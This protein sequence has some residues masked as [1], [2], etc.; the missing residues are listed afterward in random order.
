MKVLQIVPTFR[1]AGAEIMCENLCYALRES[2]CDVVAV[3]LFTEHTPITDRL[4][5]SGI[6]VI[7]LDKKLGFDVSML[8][9]LKKTIR[10]EKPD[11]VHTHI[12]AA[13][14]AM[15]AA[16][17]CHVRTKVHTVHSIAQQEQSPVGKAVNKFLYK[18]CGVT[19]VAL[20]KEI[21]DSIKT[22]Y[23]LPEQKIPVVL[24]GIDLTRCQ[25]KSGYSRAEVFKIIQIGRF[26]D[27]KNHELVLRSFAVFVKKHPDAR[28]QLVGDGELR[29]AMMH[30][31]KE[32][33]IE[34][35]VEFVGLQ[36][37]VFPWLHSADLFLLPSKYE[38][39]PMSIVEAM[40]T[41]LPII[42][43]SVGGIPDMLE[44]GNDAILIG[45][46]QSEILEALERFYSSEQLRKTC[47]QNAKIKSINF[48][49]STMAKSYLA[50]YSSEAERTKPH[51]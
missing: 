24:N 31:A 21:K 14:Y 44:N 20:S 47:G 35:V 51:E 37:D 40:G 22:V 34:N 29:P 8:A 28:L 17:F 33:Q 16:S 48:S 13:R 15:L 50:V 5:S 2:G 38:G 26:C 32:L 1:I 6:K 41:G 23:K 3:S 10:N 7:Y 25:P 39:T 46:R 49:S 36:N 18:H 19:P 43:T 30:L 12:G 27:V 42:A 11:V 9:K 4:E 45:N